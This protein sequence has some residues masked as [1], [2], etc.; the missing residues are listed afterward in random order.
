[1]RGVSHVSGSDSLQDAAPGS[2]F[3]RL[4]SILIEREGPT[5]KSAAKA[6]ALRPRP[7]RPLR[8]RLG[9]LGSLAGS[10]HGA[11]A[12]W[13]PQHLAMTRAAVS[14]HVP[15]HVPPN[16]GS[17]AAAQHE[18]SREFMLTVPVLMGSRE[19]ARCCLAWDA[20]I[21]SHALSDGSCPGRQGRTFQPR[22]P[23]ACVY[24]TL[25][26]AGASSLAAFGASL[27]SLHTTH[28]VHNRLSHSALFPC[29][30]HKKPPSTATCPVLL[31][32]RQLLVR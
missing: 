9:K 30:K 3:C 25:P 18:H 27:P 10:F 26:T 29:H 5:L 14:R 12:S 16:L 7:P 11:P 23:S 2:T 19:P 8:F 15:L 20:S 22:G 21:Q 28:S 24:S 1:M 31:R 32:S 4:C 13:H 17:R 6:S